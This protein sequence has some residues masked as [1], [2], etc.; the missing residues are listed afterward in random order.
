MARYALGFL[1]ILAGYAIIAALMAGV[2]ASINLWA[3]LDGYDE[4]VEDHIKLIELKR[5]Q[6]NQIDK[7]LTRMFDE[8]K[9]QKGWNAWQ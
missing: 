5:K 4:G 7:N 2:S 3:N 8:R 9:N 1:W 6:N